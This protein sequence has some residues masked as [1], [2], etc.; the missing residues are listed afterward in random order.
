MIVFP[1]LLIASV[2][3]FVLALVFALP[4][5]AGIVSV[6]GTATPST[7]SATAPSTVTVNWRVVRNN[8]TV[9]P[10]DGTVSSSSGRFLVGGVPVSTVSRTLSRIEPGNTAG[11]VTIVF[12]ESV[13]VPR[14]VA[15]NAV[16]SNAPI[17]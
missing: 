1:S 17:I 4:A 13:T 12:T 11:N 6:T 15:Y 8:G 9:L 16:K 10:N 14:E 2:V 7:V 3:V 5:Q